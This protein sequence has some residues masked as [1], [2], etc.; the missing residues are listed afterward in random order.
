MCRA[1]H[2]A[3]THYV[4]HPNIAL[5]VQALDF[6]EMHPELMAT[7]YSDDQSDVLAPAGVV[8]LWNTRFKNRTPE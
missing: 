2:G 8:H 3:V 5:Q 6:S 4:M 1:V 7:A